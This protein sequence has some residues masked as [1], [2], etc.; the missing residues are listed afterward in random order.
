MELLEQFGFHWVWFG[1][2]TIL[3]AIEAMVGSFRFLAASIGAAIVGGLAHFF[4]YVSF[5]VQL[6]FFVVIAAVLIWISG[7][8]LKER[9]SK[10]SRLKEI[11]ATKAYVGQQVKLV[12]GIRQGHGSIDI[13]GVVWSVK[14][15]DCP[16]GSQVKVVDMA[17]GRLIVEPLS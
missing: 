7:S 8:Y 2:A 15:R 6:L 13:D 5:P 4:P 1:L 17:E 12:G 16:E 14:G 3:L 11:V 9:M 10:V